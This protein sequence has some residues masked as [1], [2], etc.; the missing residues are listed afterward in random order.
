[1]WILQKFITGKWKR[2]KNVMECHKKLFKRSTDKSGLPKTIVLGF[3]FLK[4]L[5]DNNA[6]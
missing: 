5:E 6:L 3:I 4:I 1:M 2:S